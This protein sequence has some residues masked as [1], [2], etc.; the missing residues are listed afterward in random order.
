MA[1]SSLFSFNQ[2]PTKQTLVE[3]QAKVDRVDFKKLKQIQHRPIVALV[4]GSGGARGYAHI[5]VI[6]VLEQY[7]I[8]PDMIVGTSAGSVVGSIYASGKNAQQLRD[9]ALN[10]KANDVRDVKLAMTGFFDGQKVEDYVNEQV[11]STPLEHLKIPM[12]VVATELKEGKKVVFNYGNTGQ[13]VRA[14]V[15]IPSMFIPTKIAGEEYVDGGLVSPVPVN[16]ARE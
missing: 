8:H 7:G 12:Y 14:S 10:M 13:A 4:L 11:L 6:Q 3:A 5:G 16:V 9:I 15:S 2:N 1:Q